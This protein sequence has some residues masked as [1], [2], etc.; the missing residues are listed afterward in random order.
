MGQVDVVTSL[1]D[2]AVRVVLRT[3]DELFLPLRTL[4]IAY[5]LKCEYEYFGRV[6]ENG[7]SVYE[8]E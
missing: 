3:H 2:G 6:L 5:I 8:R 7:E 4:P 1:C